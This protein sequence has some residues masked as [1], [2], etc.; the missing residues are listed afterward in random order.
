M[1]WAQS[2]LFFRLLL[3]NTVCTSQIV[4]YAYFWR[5]FSDG[6]APKNASLT[7]DTRNWIPRWLDVIL[8]QIY[9]VFRIPQFKQQIKFIGKRPH[10]FSSTKFHPLQPQ[11]SVKCQL[12]E[13]IIHFFL[14]EKKSRSRTERKQNECA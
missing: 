1:W 4:A 13:I 6:K 11:K 7:L 5:S 14:E 9:R 12:H 2:E 3:K 10:L 8:V